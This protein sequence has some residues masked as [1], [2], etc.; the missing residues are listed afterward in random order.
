MRKP[1]N[2]LKKWTVCVLEEHSETVFSTLKFY[3]SGHFLETFREGG[4]HDITRCLC[5]RQF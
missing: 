5:V 4:M 2:Q 3:L 1:V